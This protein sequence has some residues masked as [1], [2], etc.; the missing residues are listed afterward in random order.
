VKATLPEKTRQK[1]RGKYEREARFQ[2]F[3]DEELRAVCEGRSDPA[4]SRLVLQKVASLSKEIQRQRE[5]VRERRR[6]S[7]WS[8]EGIS[9]A[10]LMLILDYVQ[11][12]LDLIVHSQSSA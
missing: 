3:I 7:N 2:F 1:P 8:P 12:Q 11:E 6:S 9:R 4:A 5:E 10:E